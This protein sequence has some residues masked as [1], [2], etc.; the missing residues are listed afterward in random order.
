[1]K[2]LEFPILKEDEYDHFRKVY[3]AIKVNSVYEEILLELYSGDTKKMLNVVLTTNNFQS[4]EKKEIGL[5]KI[6]NVRKKN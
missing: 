4:I 6:V 2:K 1:M 3:S 5:R